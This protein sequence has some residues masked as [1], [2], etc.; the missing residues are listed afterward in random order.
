MDV[1]DDD[2][3]VRAGPSAYAYA[4]A[5]NLANDSTVTDKENIIHPIG[6]LVPTSIARVLR[7]FGVREIGGRERNRNSTWRYMCLVPFCW[8]VF[9]QWTPVLMGLGIPSPSLLSCRN[10]SFFVPCSQWVLRDCHV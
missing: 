6:E 5:E 2:D 3:D 1:D 7:C 9:L 8:C 10:R 4:S